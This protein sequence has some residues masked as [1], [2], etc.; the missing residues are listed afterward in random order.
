[1]AIFFT[2]FAGVVTYIFGQL[3]LKLVIEP[4]QETKRT[5]AQISHSLIE[6]ANVISNPGVPP[7]EVMR[8]T[9]Q[10]L[11]GLSSKIRSHLYLVPLYDLTAKVFFMPNQE[12]ILCAAQNL[13]GLSNSVYTATDRIYEFNA[14][15]VEAICDS[16]GIY[17]AEGD[18]WPAE[19]EDAQPDNQADG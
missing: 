6:H 7:M 1:M 11:R 18:R 15:R 16:L 14:R 8:E 2:I 12:S 9:S 4:V 5:I 3:V 13:M 19:L 17:M 10:H